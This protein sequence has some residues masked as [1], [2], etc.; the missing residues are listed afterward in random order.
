M[1]EK[2]GNEE[3]EFTILFDIFEEIE[4]DEGR[5]T[6]KVIKRNCKRKWFITDTY[7]LTDVREIPSQKGT[8]YKNK[9]EIYNRAENRWITIEGNY[10]EIKNRIRPIERNKIKGFK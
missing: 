6:V 3:F 10:K 9:C 4:D 2:N 8:P 7:N 1:L 5:T